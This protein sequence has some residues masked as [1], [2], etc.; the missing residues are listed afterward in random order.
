MFSIQLFFP[1][2]ALIAPAIRRSCLIEM[3]DTQIYMYLIFY[4]LLQFIT[5][6]TR[7]LLT[8]LLHQP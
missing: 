7:I 5:T 1:R 4:H 8:G 2:A 3:R 6:Y